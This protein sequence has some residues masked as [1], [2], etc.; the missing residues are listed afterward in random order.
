MPCHAVPGWIR[1]RKRSRRRVDDEP[2]PSRSQAGEKS[3]THQRRIRDEGE[4]RDGA[5]DESSRGHRPAAVARAGRSAPGGDAVVPAP[6]PGP[7]RPMADGPPSGADG[8]AVVPGRDE[9]G[10]RPRRPLPHAVRG[11][12]GAADVGRGRG[13]I[14][15]RSARDAGRRARP[16]GGRRPGG[17]RPAPAAG[18]SLARPGRTPGRADVPGRGLG[19]T[20][21]RRGGRGPP[22]RR[23]GGRVP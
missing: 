21:V 17:R 16:R 8:A 2:E 14:R 7:R 9:R 5:S 20:R 19:L 4:P 1:S 12:A 15:L 22:R 11:R 23:G 6:R 3:E 18:A 13:G 10:G